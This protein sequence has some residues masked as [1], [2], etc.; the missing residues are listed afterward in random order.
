M[1]PTRILVVEDER[2]IG[3]DVQNTL[4]QLGYVVPDVARTGEEALE[5]VGQIEPDLVLMDIR[6]SGGMDGI[7]TAAR[8]KAEHGSPVIFLT[9]LADHETIARAKA[10]EPYG[11]LLK[12][13]NDRELQ[14]TVEMAVSRSRSQRLLEASAKHFSNTLRSLADGV[15]ATDLV[16]NITFLNPLAEALTGW[17]S[18]EALGRPL[19]EIF[20]I[21]RPG[22]EE[23]PPM[24][25]GQ[26]AGEPR[27]VMLHSR[28]GGKFPI[29]DNSA[30]M[31]NDDG[32]LAGLVVVFRKRAIPEA[33]AGDGAS[34]PLV[35]LVEGIADP[36][37]AVGA[38]WVITFANQQAARLF[39]KGRSEIVGRELW[40]EFPPSVRSQYFDAFSTVLNKRERG[41]IELQVEERGLWFGVEIYPFGEG[42]ADPVA[43][44]QFAQGGRATA[45]ALGEARELGAAGSRVRPRFQQPA[46][47]P[48][49]E[50]LAGADEAPQ[51]P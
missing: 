16:G 17:P 1:K 18:E 6:L 14:S 49:G 25:T 45:P 42:P 27:P 39:N 32:S 33:E 34:A 5:L 13:F 43:R 51:G 40:G 9:A 26:G 48:A 20:R 41:T 38:D 22:G 23:A 10:T 35:G 50:Y 12:P 19:Q 7:E 36:L 30:P 15:I 29:E 2:V 47:S 44:Y 46:D 37:V 4:V 11:Y 3:R 8:I 28:S 21:T 31:K 24:E